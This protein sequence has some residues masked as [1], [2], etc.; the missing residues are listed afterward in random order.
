MNSVL[1][2]NLY[3][4]KLK[5][6]CQFGYKIGSQS[7]ELISPVGRVKMRRIVRLYEKNKLGSF[8]AENIKYQYKMAKHEHNEI[9]VENLIDN[10][11]SALKTL[12]LIKHNIR[13]EYE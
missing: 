4:E 2:K 13:E 7:N 3:K 10:G 5:I 12:N 8:L 6:A 11:F 9:F 1:I